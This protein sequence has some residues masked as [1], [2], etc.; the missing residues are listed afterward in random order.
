MPGPISNSKLYPI[1]SKK[2]E[3]KRKRI[4]HAVGVL[5]TEQ[6]AQT[7]Y[8]EGIYE[9]F[10]PEQIKSHIPQYHVVPYSRGINPKPLSAAQINTR[11][12]KSKTLFFKFFMNPYQDLDYMVL[13]DIYANSIAGR[14][15]DTK[16]QLKFGNGVRPVLRLILWKYF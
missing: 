15:I 16:E 5:K 7:P 14:I 8:H 2:P 9:T 6:E 4:F 13:G 12:N 3:E 11:R 10:S 1:Y